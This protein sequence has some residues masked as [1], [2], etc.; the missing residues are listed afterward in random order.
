MIFYIREQSSFSLSGRTFRSDIQKLLGAVY[1]GVTVVRA[2]SHRD[3]WEFSEIT[4]Y[5]SIISTYP[6]IF[7]N[8]TSLRY[9]EKLLVKM[10]IYLRKG[11]VV[12]L[13]IR[14]FLLL[15]L[16]AVLK[17]CSESCGRF[18]GLALLLAFVRLGGMLVA[19][20]ANKK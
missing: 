10:C 5:A 4:K 7:N 19:E 18:T 1:N 17:T 15:V 3:E 12:V 9:I 8:Y 20:D 11:N 2:E 14:G 13:G 16:V 6:A